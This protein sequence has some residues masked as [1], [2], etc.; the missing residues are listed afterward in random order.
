MSSQASIDISLLRPCSPREVIVKPIDFGG[1]ID[2]EGEVC[3][4][5]Y[6]MLTPMNGRKSMLKNLTWRRS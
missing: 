1:G 2:S 4:Y 6:L 3:F 5:C